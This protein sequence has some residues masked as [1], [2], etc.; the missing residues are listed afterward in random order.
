M[1]IHSSRGVLPLHEMSV[2]SCL[3][4]GIVSTYA[5][6]TQ[7]TSGAKPAIWSF[8]FSSTFFEMNMGKAQFLTPNFLILALNHV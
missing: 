5:W 8:S 4:A 6:V 3:I 1:A 7:A 2:R